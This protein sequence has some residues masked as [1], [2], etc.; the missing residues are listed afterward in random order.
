MSQ[1]YFKERITDFDQVGVKALDD[2]T[3][4]AIRMKN[5][6]VSSRYDSTKNRFG[7]LKLKPVDELELGE[8]SELLDELRPVEEVLQKLRQRWAYFNPALGVG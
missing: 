8:V 3:V 7:I 1:D 5:R 4:K 2:H 6:I